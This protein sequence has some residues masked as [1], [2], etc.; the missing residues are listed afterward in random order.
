MGNVCSNFKK[1]PVVQ[2]INDTSDQ[3]PKNSTKLSITDNRK[4]QEIDD[5]TIDDSHRIVE[6]LTHLEN[7]PDAIVQAKSKE[8][9][10]HKTNKNTPNSGN[11]EASN[12]AG[13]SLNEEERADKKQEEPQSQDEELNLAKLKIDCGHALGMKEEKD[14]MLLYVAGGRPGS[15]IKEKEVDLPQYT[16]ATD[17]GEVSVT[18]K[19]WWGSYCRAGK[20][21]RGKRKGNQDSFVICDR[22]DLI[23][24]VS[25]FGVFDGHGVKGGYVSQFVRDTFPKAFAEEYVTKLNPDEDAVKIED[26]QQISSSTSDKIS[27]LLETSD[28]N[29][30][31]SGTTAVTMM[32]RGQDVFMSN[33]GDSRAIIA[34][35][36][37]EERRYK[38]L[39]STI[40]HKPDLPSEKKRILENEGDV[41]TIGVARV[42]LK[43]TH[44]PGL[45][46]S[47][48]FG[49]SVAT[50]VGVTSEPDVFYAHVEPNPDHSSFAV[51]ASDGMWEFIDTDKCIEIVSECIESRKTPQD[52][53]D[54]L[55]KESVC[56][57]DREDDV[58]D[59]ITVL[60][61]FFC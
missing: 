32:V 16:G 6:R 59:D 52:A 13:S 19:V 10:I 5:D 48:S 57:W 53:C 31:V 50:T 37:S 55:V 18:N 20:D 40:D 4:V 27:Q 41:F 58:V 15:T 14:G 45:A 39:C 9:D 54:I 7:M 21:L 51:I 17:R 34:Q 36:D 60:V 23:P 29:I 2:R 28:I 8:Y 43:G 30:G 22:F 42:G 1:D 24:N 11:N 47:R 49:D 3:A 44:R 12:N 46:L 61:V 56:A 38:T 33:V 35:Y 26:M 25:L